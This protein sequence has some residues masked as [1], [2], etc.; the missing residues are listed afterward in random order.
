MSSYERTVILPNGAKIRVDRGIAEAVKVLN[1]KGYATMFCCEGHIVTD[2]PTSR[3]QYGQY[4]PL[5]IAF[6]QGCMPPYSPNIYPKTDI[7]DGW[8]VGHAREFMGAY[9]PFKHQPARDTLFISFECYKRERKKFSEGDVN[10]EHK[11]ILNAVLE[12]A[13]SLPNREN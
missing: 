1:E 10:K 13:N 12:W 7:T 4:S 5:W 8:V 2:I 9:K 6:K 11:R 3:R